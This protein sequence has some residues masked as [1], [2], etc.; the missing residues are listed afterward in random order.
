M[1]FTLLVITDGRDE[2]CIRSLASA[3][4][5]LPSP[6]R[7][8]LVDDRTHEL[9]FAGAV[10]H[11]WNQILATDTEWVFH[12][13]A[14]FLFNG[15]VDL[16]AMAELAADEHV[17]QVAL[18]RQPWNEQEKKAGGIVELDTDSF[19]EGE[20]RHR[21]RPYVLGSYTAHRKCFTT[22]PCLYRRDI[23]ERGW[24]QVPKS[25]GMF[26]LGLF[27]DPAI[28]STFWG[29]KFDAPAVTHIGDE[30]QGTGY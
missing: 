20:V 19:E 1:K 18:K 29:G 6:E 9:G 15:P 28:V 10:Q 14:D 27:S 24:P 30:R 17:C 5:N 4:E 23:A 7:V 22:N 3:L 21:Y 25:E 16:E 26:S 11:G 8:V 12:L 13:E 2:Y